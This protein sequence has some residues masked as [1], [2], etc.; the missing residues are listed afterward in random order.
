MFLV[1]EPW[2]TQVKERTERTTLGRFRI[3]QKQFIRIL[4]TTVCPYPE[5]EGR[6]GVLSPVQL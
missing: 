2:L 1:C 3:A 5:A 4:G 6:D